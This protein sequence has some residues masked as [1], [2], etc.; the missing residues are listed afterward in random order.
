MSR[1]GVEVSLLNIPGSSGSVLDTGTFFVAGL[2]ERGPTNQAFPVNGLSELVEKSGNRVSYSPLYDTLELFFREGGGRA[3]IARVVGPGATSGSLNLMDGSAAVSLVATANGPGAWSNQ[4]KVAVAAGSVGGTYRIQVYDTT[5]VL[6]ED[7]GDLVD[8]GSAVAWSA[9][10]D[11]I[12]ITLGASALNPAVA[13]ATVLPAGNDDRAAVTD[14]QWQA[15]LDRI[16]TDLGPGQVAAPGRT[17]TTG[18]NQL[19]AH[20]EARNRVALLDMPNTGTV[21]TL[22]AINVR[23]RFAAKFAPWVFVP[24][25]SIGTTRTVPPCGLIAG[26][27]ARNDPTLGTNRP[28]A[29]DAGIS[30]FAT[31]LSQPN[32]NDSDRQTLNAAGVNVIRRL[33]GIRVYGWRS[34][35]DPVADIN[36]L[37]F[38]NARLYTDISSELD[39]AAESYMFAE[40]DGV[41]GSAVR[42]LHDTCVSVLKDHY[43]RGEL[44]GAAPEEAFFVDTGPTV[45]TPDTIQNL[46]LHAAC[47]VRMAP[48]AEWIKIQIVKYPVT[49]VL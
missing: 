2:T 43:D 47:Y 27:I 48:F 40:I 35:A 14:T 23:S 12:R 21:A 18:M 39:D 16:T 5:N 6:L 36:W 7:S 22:L 10:S 37:P 3:Y 15:A 30:L 13:A 44:F 17:T 24:G 20:A 49:Q 46:E 4:Y 8:Q 42:G 34:C 45:N 19:I 1:P 31:D 29:G 33:A 32:W 28:S 25:L 41:G 9:Y 38:S 26:L 11:F